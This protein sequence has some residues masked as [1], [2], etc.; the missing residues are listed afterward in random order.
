MREDERLLTCS[1]FLVKFSSSLAFTLLALLACCQSLAWHISLF[2]HRHTC[3]HTPTP[4][5]T[6]SH[7]IAVCTWLVIIAPYC[8]SSTICFCQNKLPS[9]L[10]LW[11]DWIIKLWFKFLSPIKNSLLSRS[12]WDW[13]C[14]SSW[15]KRHQYLNILI[16][17]WTHFW[18]KR[19]LINYLSFHY[20]IAYKGHW[21][22]C[23][24]RWR[25]G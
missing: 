4:H 11:L 16:F 15:P 23:L 22:L 12:G 24:K 3:T 6:C 2:T 19:T 10:M 1:V 25:A 13:F 7:F 14:R 9:R 20:Y 18:S 17:S 5:N 21:L 8:P